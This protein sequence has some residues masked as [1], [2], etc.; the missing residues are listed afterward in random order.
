MGDMSYYVP[1]LDKEAA[2]WR[3]MLGFPKKVKST[4]GGNAAFGGADNMVNPTVST[5]DKPFKRARSGNSMRKSMSRVR[6]G[7]NNP[8]SGLY[9]S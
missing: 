9:R 7:V 5:T 1:E 8:S 2:D 3:K 6:M 4:T